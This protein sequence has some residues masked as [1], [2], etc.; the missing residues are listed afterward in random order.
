MVVPEVAEPQMKE[1]TVLPLI[2]GLPVS[3]QATMV[4]AMAKVA[5]SMLLIPSYWAGAG[6]GWFS[7]GTGGNN[8]ISILM[9]WT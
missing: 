8:R 4:E 1:F 6:A 7:D 3:I 5:D 9:C 2:W